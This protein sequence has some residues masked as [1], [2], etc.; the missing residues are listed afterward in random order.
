MHKLVGYCDRWSV[1]PRE[2]IR[3]MVSSAG[4]ASFAPRF[5]RHLCADPNPRGPGYEEVVMPTPCDGVRAGR[6]QPAW[7]GSFGRA[8]RLRVAPAPGLAITATVWPTTP[9]KGVQGIVALHGKGWAVAIEI[10]ANGGAA[11]VVVADG[12]TARAE[13][14]AMGCRC[15]RPRR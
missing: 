9:R 6:F 5:V 14:A 1:R 12:R 2:R 13:V 10:A 4:D 3:F 8:S 7:L 15:R 11:L